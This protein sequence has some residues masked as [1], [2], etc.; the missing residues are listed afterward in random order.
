M[1]SYY[2]SNIC[3]A[4]HFFKLYSQKQT[5]P[6]AFKRPWG[7][8]LGIITLTTHTISAEGRLCRHRVLLPVLTDNL[9]KELE[10]VLV[11][12]ELAVEGLDQGHPTLCDIVHDLEVQ[13]RATAASSRRPGP[14]PGRSWSA[15]RTDGAT[16]ATRTSP[17]ELGG[18]RLRLPGASWHPVMA[19]ERGSQPSPA[20]L[21]QRLAG[22][23]ARDQ[24][25]A[26]RRT[27]GGDGMPSSTHLESLVPGP[28]SDADL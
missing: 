18:R 25:C 14:S 6:E 26:P 7:N 12:G 28:G 27:R 2:S 16:A 11:L 23:R 22:R 3:L 1:T 13:A 19:G 17:T 4:E 21:H 24:S 10:A 20:S 8:K 15:C 5:I 9:K